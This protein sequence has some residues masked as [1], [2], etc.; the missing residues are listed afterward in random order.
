MTIILDIG[1]HLE[2]VQTQQW[3]QCLFPLSGVK[4]GKVPSH[5]ESLERHQQVTGQ[6]SLNQLPFSESLIFFVILMLVSLII[7]SFCRLSACMSLLA[8]G[9][10]HFQ[11]FT[12]I[13]EDFNFLFCGFFHNLYWQF[14][15]PCDGI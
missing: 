14:L 4:G 12:V 9:S 1:L 10:S 8:T 11:V 3:K 7:E 2:S 5:L 15:Q 13:Y 6:F